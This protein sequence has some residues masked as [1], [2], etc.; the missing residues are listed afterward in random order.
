MAS[1]EFVAGDPRGRYNT[2]SSARRKRRF[3]S[4]VPYVT[5]LQ[6]EMPLHTHQ[7]F[8]SIDDAQFQ[9]PQPDRELAGSSPGF[10][11]QSNSSSQLS[12]MAPTAIGIAGSS[13]PHN[14]MQP[15]LALLF[16][17]ALQ[18]IFPARG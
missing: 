8:G 7:Q 17:I 10:L 16:I 11:Y 5:L 15:S 2:S 4:G 18:G 12:T 14:N 1:D 13:L 9:S 3:S 6:S